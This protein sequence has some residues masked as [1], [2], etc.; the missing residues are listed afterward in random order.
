[1]YESTL[2]ACLLLRW[3]CGRFHP[4]AD[5]QIMEWAILVVGDIKM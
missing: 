3:F 4:K 1:M 2:Y 5:T